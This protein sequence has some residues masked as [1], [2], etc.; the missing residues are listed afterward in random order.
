MLAGRRRCVHHLAAG[1]HRR[2]RTAGAGAIEPGHVPHPAFRRQ[3]EP[4]REIGLHYQIHRGIGVHH[5]AA[6]AGE[7]LRVN[8]FV[9]GAPAMTWPP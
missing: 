4:N 9:G 3:Y 5:A 1:L 7:P 6:P 8:I 2:H